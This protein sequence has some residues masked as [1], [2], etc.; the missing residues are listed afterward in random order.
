MVKK[1]HGGII[2]KDK[3]HERAFHSFIKNSSEIQV[4]SKTPSSLLIKCKLN[5][6]VLKDSPYLMLRPEDYKSPI[7]CILIK[8]G[9]VVTNIEN[10]NDTQ[11]IYIDKFINLY[12][13][14]RERERE[15]EERKKQKMNSND[16]KFKNYNISGTKQNFID[17]INIQTDV[18]LKTIEYLDPICPGVVYGNVIDDIL[19]SINFISELRQKR[20]DEN[21]IILLTEL[22]NVFV[23]LHQLCNVTTANNFIRKIFDE[24]VSNGID[25]STNNKVNML[26][27]MHGL[28]NNESSKFNIGLGI[29]AMEFVD[30]GYKTFGNLYN[31]ILVN[32]FYKDQLENYENMARL[33]L[34]DLAL[35]TGYSQCDFHLSNIMINPTLPGYYEGYEGRVMLI[36]FGYAKKIPPE[37]LTEIKDSYKNKDYMNCIKIIF[38]LGRMDGGK[39]IFLDY[40]PLFGWIPHLYNNLGQ[41]PIENTEEMLNNLNEEIGSLIIAQE[42]AINERILHFEYLHELDGM[43][44]PLLSSLP[45]SETSETSE[46]KNSL[47]KGMIKEGGRRRKNKK[48]RTQQRHRKSRKF[49]KSKTYKKAQEVA[50]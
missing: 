28:F 5:P 45:S 19:E 18:F 7:D 35:K 26:T 15:R 8:L 32:G 37:K 23:Y 29:I 13:Q 31:D 30:N 14:M 10:I 34:I 49:K 2:I 24:L 6:R 36:D 27:Y 17:E 9:L 42:K 43:Y 21:S 39:N 44:Y 11:R 22:Q 20:S 4:I 33:K 41:K 48:H 40:L 16:E 12:F 25:N 46:I 1:Q 47:F 3:D 50:K 38:D